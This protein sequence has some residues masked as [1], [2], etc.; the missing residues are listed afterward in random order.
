MKP[1]SPPR[2]VVN[3]RAVRALLGRGWYVG[4]W[5]GGD[6]T[7]RLYAV[8]I[9]DR[10][11]ELVATAYLVEVALKVEAPPVEAAAWVIVPPDWLQSLQIPAAGRRERLLDDLI[12]VLCGAWAEDEEINGWELAGRLATAFPQ[13]ISTAGTKRREG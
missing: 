8:E 9:R 10:R 1:V 4:V 12:R 3:D 6:S 13:A 2:E 7:A 5:Q 11:R